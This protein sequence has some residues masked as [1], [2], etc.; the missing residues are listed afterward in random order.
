VRLGPPPAL[1]WRTR[2]SRT[3]TRQGPSPQANHHQRGKGR[4]P[5]TAP[6]I[7]KKRG[8]QPEF[9]CLCC[10]ENCTKSQQAVKCIMCA[11]WAHKD[12]IKMP[13]STF[14][15]PEFPCLCCG[16]N[17]TKSQQAVKCIMCALWA[18]KDC[19]KMPD[20]TLSPWTSRCANQG[21]PTGCAD[22][23][24]ALGNEYS[25]SSLKVIRDMT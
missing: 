9:P 7:K 15:F 17:C 11:L 20:S 4:V 23:V 19:I 16:E 12:C 10:G 22:H 8:R 24:K 14:F 13:D 18:H 6:R 5:A 2:W 3:W 21:R 1:L 25:I